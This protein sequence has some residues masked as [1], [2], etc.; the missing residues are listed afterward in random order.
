M[1]TILFDLD[2]TLLPMDVHHFTKLYFGGLQK[3]FPQ[4]DAKKLIDGVLAGMKQMV[5]NNGSRTNEQAFIPAFEQA[6][7]INFAENEAAFL[8]YYRTDFAAVKAACTLPEESAQLID[9]LQNK[10]YQVA[11]ATNPLFPQIATYSRLDW[12][13]LDPKRF[14]LVTTY[15]DSHFAKPNPAYYTEVAQRLG[16]L[17]TDC[18]MIGNDVVEDGAAAQVGMT[19]MLVTDCL[20]NSQDLPTDNFWTGGMQQLLAWAEALPSV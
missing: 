2:G 15:E 13:G 3:A 1:S 19:V 16:V 9:I 10:G 5:S 11:I 17:P 14:P 12:L 6:S 20:L 7:G 4:Y 8:Q 18:I